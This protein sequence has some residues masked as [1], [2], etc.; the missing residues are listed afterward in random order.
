MRDN[1]KV[2]KGSPAAIGVFPDFKEDKKV[3]IAMISMNMGTK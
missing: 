1:G 2:H 3:L